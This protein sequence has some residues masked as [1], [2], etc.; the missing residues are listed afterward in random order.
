LR[1]QLSGRALAAAGLVAAALAAPAAVRADGT[2][3]LRGF[4]YK[5]KAT[6]VIQPM[7][8]GNF[9]VGDAGE[10]DVHALVD[11]ITSA[12]AAA[13]ALG[14]PF[15]ERRWEL[16]GAYRHRLADLRIGGSA[17]ISYEPDYQSFFVGV[18]SDLAL[19]AQTTVIGVAAGIGHDAIGRAG[20]GGLGGMSASVG[21][22]TT[23]L[24]SVSLTQILSPNAVAGV[25]YD[26]IFLDGYQ[27]NPY[28]SV[29][30]ADGM[31]P[32]R[33]PDQRTRHAVAGT[34]RRFVPQTATAL[35]AIYRYYTDSWELR[36]HT[37]ELRLVQEAGDGV[38]LTL[39]YRLHRQGQ[40]FF[41][42]PSYPSASPTEFPYL[43]DDVKLSAFTSHT[44]GVKFGVHGHVFGLGGRLEDARGELVL[45]YVAQDN[46]FGNAVLAN[47]ALILPFDY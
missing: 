25:T 40:A 20:P 8:D 15:S 18:A 10:A 36:A 47:A 37:P 33:H 32:E 34:V 28:R 2:L 38:D 1:V 44:L 41:Y 7:L 29:I 4:W 35:I 3:A 5:E 43:T 46:R 27:E 26:L 42:R 12:S 39:R 19:A 23:A 45:E 17:R 13:G 14:E 16:G 31:V 11:A 24:G 22:L 21:D 30:T 9:D 6:R